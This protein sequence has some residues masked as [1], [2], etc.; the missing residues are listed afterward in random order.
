MNRYV[1][2]KEYVN[3]LIDDI[4]KM[5]FYENKIGC[6]YSIVDTF[7]QEYSNY[8]EHKNKKAFCDFIL[9][10]ADKGVYDYLD[11]IEPITL[12]Y[13]ISK[14]KMKFKELSDANIYSVNSLGISEL[15]K[16]IVVQNSEVSEKNNHT[17]ISLL[18]KNRS[19]II[20]ESDSTGLIRVKSEN[21]YNYPIYLDYTSYWRF[22]FPYKFLKE[23]FLNCI[24]NYLLN[25]EKLNLDPF[26][27]NQNRKSEYAFYD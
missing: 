13:D 15:R 25:Q 16:S 9:S 11:L 12:I 17:Y 6:L 14:K 5:E 23:L 22:I 1:E 20:H 27:N 2:I 10:F 4:E 19:R 18:Y 21:E 7:A 8:S 24:E 3:R 26:E